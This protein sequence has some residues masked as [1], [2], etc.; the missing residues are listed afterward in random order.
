[1]KNN[2]KQKLKEKATGSLM[3]VK[4]GTWQEQIDN[5]INADFGQSIGFYR[6]SKFKLNVSLNGV[7]GIDA[8]GS[9]FGEKTLKM[10][11]PKA[12]NDYLLEQI[13]AYIDSEKS[14]ELIERNEKGILESLAIYKRKLVECVDKIEHLEMLKIRLIREEIRRS[15]L[16]GEGCSV[17]DY[18]SLNKAIKRLER[19]YDYYHSSFRE[20]KPDS[21]V[22]NYCENKELEK[23]RLL[24]SIQNAI[25]PTLFLNAA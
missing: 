5:L 20:L 17:V 25:Q 19:S 3:L 10:K 23:I 6:R 2:V 11:F 24:K 14:K 18:K 13:S 16:L 9:Y 4:D 8:V 1:M 7:V 22:L 12:L 15:E 21:L